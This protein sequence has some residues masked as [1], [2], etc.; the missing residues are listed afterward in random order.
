MGL[1][2]SPFL[3]FLLTN[4]SVPPKPGQPL[5]EKYKD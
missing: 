1:D 4:R 2:H 5:E 3:S